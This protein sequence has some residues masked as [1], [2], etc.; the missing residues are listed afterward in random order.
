LTD[1]KAG[2]ERKRKRDKAM[3]WI[4]NAVQRVRDFAYT[5]TAPPTVELPVPARR[6]RVGVA[7]GGG[8]ARGIAHLG[9][10]HALQE[11]NIPVDCIAGTSAGAL[12]GLAFASGR[13]FDEVV[14]KASAIRFGNFGQWRISKM[15][16]ASNQRLE[17]YPEKFLGVKTFEDLTVPMSIAATDL[18]SGEAVYYTSGPLG[19]PL[20]A[21]CAYPG[22]FQPVEYD[23][24]MLVDGFV[25]A[26]VPVDAARLM[27]AEVVIAV[28]L[29]AE[30]LE[31]PANLVDVI[32]R[33]FSIVRLQADVGWRLKSDI[34][35][36]PAVR[37]FAWDDFAR[38]R[39]LV[40]AG[41][42]SALEALPQIQAALRPVVTQAQPS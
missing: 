21:S 35:I 41:E 32:G 40:A 12:A 33:S 27:G 30:S 15:G 1:V 42:A 24:R 25:S 5:P 38:T 39:D 6:P 14:R 20:R 9:V 10:L 8:F 29:E 4:E 2:K 7:L 37:E 13:P 26:A 22:L 31:K 36:T 16:L 19:P 17:A 34:V 11:H 23:G 28:F 18:V 3:G